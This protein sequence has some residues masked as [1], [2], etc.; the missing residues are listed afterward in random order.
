MRGPDLALALNHPPSLFLSQFAAALKA[1]E[2]ELGPIDILV[3]NAGTSVPGKV[4]K[5][6]VLALPTTTTLFI[7]SSHPSIHFPPQAA[8]WSRIPP[9]PAGRWN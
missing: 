3:C 5:G 2:D 1:V 7:H 9:P 6:G 4:E 8:S